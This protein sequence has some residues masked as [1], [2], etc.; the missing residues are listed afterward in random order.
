[1]GNTHYYHIVGDGHVRGTGG[2]NQPQL[3]E[4]I[5][6]MTLTLVGVATPPVLN[7]I[8]T[9]ATSGAQAR[10]TSLQDG[11]GG[12]FILQLLT[13]NA[14]AYT[15]GETAN[16]DSGGSGVMLGIASMQM[17]PGLLQFVPESKDAM[18]QTTSPTGLGDTPWWD[19]WC[20]TASEVTVAAGWT[21]TFTAGQRVTTSGGGAF[22]VV[23]VTA[24]GGGTLSLKVARKTGTIAAAQTITGPTGSGTISVYQGDLA[25][26]N[27]IQHNHMPNIGGLGTYFERI[28]HGS[29]VIRSDGTADATIGVEKWILEQAITKHTAS[30]D[31]TDRGVRVVPFSTFD[32]TPTK[33][34]IGGV[35]IQTVECSG[36]FPVTWTIGETVTGPGGWSATVHSFNAT[37]KFLHVVEPNGATLGAGT[38]TG[39]TSGATATAIACHGWQKGSSYWNNWK[40]NKDTSLAA[41]NGLFSSAAAK[42]EGAFLMLWEG[43]LGSLGP[44]VLAT[45][46]TIERVVEEWLRFLAD[47]RT[48]L[49]NSTMPITLFYGD[50]RQ[51]GSDLPGGAYL[52]RSWLLSVSVKATKVTLTTAD[53]LE[54]QKLGGL[55]N[56][57]SFLYWRP[58]DYVEIGRRA[59]RSLEFA[60]SE[61][62]S[63][64]F[65]PLPLILLAGQSHAVGNVPFAFA[66]MDNDPDLYSSVSFPGVSTIDPKV[67]MWHASAHVWQNYDAG[68]NG[69]TFFAP[70][71]G[72]FGSECSLLLRQKYRFGL[73]GA[74]GEVGMIKLA[75][76]GSSVSS[77]SVGAPACWDPNGSARSTTTASM[78]VTAQAASLPAVPARGR[79]T[80]TA[81]TFSSYQ[82]LAAVT[83]TGSAAGQLGAGGNNTAPDTIA[84]VHAVAPDGTWVELIGPFVNEGPRSFT[85]T[86]GPIPLVDR[87]EAEIRLALEKCVTQLRRI[88]K[89]VLKV[90][91]QAEGDLLNIAPYKEALLRTLRWLE[92]IFGQ[93]HKGETPVATVIMELTGRTP[94]QVS[95]TAI[96]QLQQIQAEVAAE[97]GNAVVVSTSSLPQESAGIFPRTTR[98]HNGIH[99]TPRGYIQAGYLADAGANGLIGIPD[100]PATSPLAGVDQF[101][102][103]AADA[104]GGSTDS[105][106]D[107]TTDAT[108]APATT[109]EAET[110]TAAVDG[111]T[112]QS[113]TTIMQQI[114]E[115]LS[116]GGIDI[117]G[118]TINGRTVQNRSLSELIELHRYVTAQQQRDRGIRRTR[119]RFT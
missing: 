20:K 97:L 93:R 42:H 46:P 95:D 3:L 74:P 34:T 38:V 21:G 36:T 4:P 86:L 71:A 63:G 49:G 72:L 15:N 40:A 48:E 68:L 13:L 32:D 70:F 12:V 43:E 33:A 58:L 112:G 26:G 64:N 96:A 115:A 30:I 16:F 101:V 103:G 14:L 69:N 62:A 41:T 85:L 6:G 24:G 5:A 8:V 37:A 67:W 18:L 59:W 45:I 108:D 92:D 19:R 23:L 31:A 76:G 98:Q 53:G 99:H 11:G 83:V 1:M 117:A 52:L 79:F 61:P 106:T 113:A 27:W 39:A 114:E 91:W 28:P 110:P 116:A 35:V 81:G 10:V 50:V 111:M 22:T 65:E 2:G 60:M 87:V 54:G 29:G 119:V 84:N 88:P 107:A 73:D 89:P 56:P 25:A 44:S 66:S 75:V 57:T 82:N 104:G 90:W 55:P 100:Y 51:H 78:T 80:A 77:T 7:T 102:D 9:G 94:W 109:D 105:G 17:A 47:F 118:Y